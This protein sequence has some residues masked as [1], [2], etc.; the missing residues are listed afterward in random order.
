VQYLNVMEQRPAA[1]STSFDSALASHLEQI[2]DDEF[3]ALAHQQVVVT[4]SGTA[5]EEYL[6]CKLDGASGYCLLALEALSQVVLPRHRFAL[7]PAMPGWM[8]GLVAWRG[9][10]L[11]V[12]DL[13]AY[14]A[15]SKYPR[16]EQPAEG[17]LL[18]TNANSEEKPRLSLLAPAIGPTATI[19]PEQVRVID[20]AGT[21]TSD[22]SGALADWLAPSRMDVARG[23]YNGTIVL[24]VHALLAD[25][26]QRIGM[27]ALDE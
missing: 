24:N 17:I 5:R 10:T 18:V 13:A 22:V 1:I 3:W 4:E 7:L 12:V 23:S 2:S 8:I 26:V 20:A 6:E 15:D 21:D 11:A 27:A 9:D 16:I 25:I 19:S 14:L